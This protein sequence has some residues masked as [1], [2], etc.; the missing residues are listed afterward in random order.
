MMKI[1][2]RALAPCAAG[3]LL[4]LA[5]SSGAP[6]P[7]RAAGGALPA[8]ASQAMQY[9]V[10]AAKQQEW[11][12]AIKYFAKAREAAPYAPKVLFNLALAYNNAGNRELVAIAWF[13]AYLAAAPGAANAEQVRAR[14][15]ALKIKVEADAAKLIA[16][17]HEAAGQIDLD[18]LHQNS[19]GQHALVYI[20]LAEAMTGD[21]SAATATAER[22]SD[23]NSRLDAYS[24]IAK[25]QAEAGDIAGAGATLARIP[26]DY[27]YGKWYRYLDIAE[28]QGRAGDIDG[29]HHSIALAIA[30][31]R[32]DAEAANEKIARV[33][34]GIGHAGHALATAA[35]IA[36]DHARSEAYSSIAIALAH[37]GDS[38]A[39]MNAAERTGFYA[40][41]YNAYMFIAIDAVEAGD[42][43]RAEQTAALIPDDR[44]K[45]VVYRYIALARA[46]AG[47][48]GAARRAIALVEATDSKVSL[49]GEPTIAEINL[50]IA[51]GDIRYRE[52]NDLAGSA[53]YWRDDMYLQD[54]PGYVRSLAGEEPREVIV[55]L[56]LAAEKR[57]EILKDL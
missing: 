31:A 36:D 37:T 8:E 42:I 51:N 12:V 39:A 35:N 17:A 56:A 34:A 26:D 23:A 22:I 55:M 11:Q 38:A 9:G 27:I 20:A 4:F 44:G 30:G 45:A 24:S 16:K 46:R 7:A 53:Q 15:I 47:D 1:D 3:A 18:A 52:I 43:A 2:W 14:I 21:F 33:E 28:A 54:V 40:D 50:Y 49:G 13:R 10:A 19:S 48:S 29:A 41:M 25:K 57:A 6:I 5:A 32:G